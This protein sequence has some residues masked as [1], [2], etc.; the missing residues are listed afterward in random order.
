[1][2]GFTTHDT[3]THMY[4]SKA[5]CANLEKKLWTGCHALHQILDPV[6]TGRDVRSEASQDAKIPRSNSTVH[7]AGNK[8]HMTQVS[9]WDP[10]PFIC[11]QDLK[12]NWWE[13]TFP[14]F[15]WWSGFVAISMTIKFGQ[16][17]Q[18]SVNENS[19]NNN[20]SSVVAV[21]CMFAANVAPWQHSKSCV[22]CSQSSISTQLLSV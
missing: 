7:T 21:V 6:H 22:W 10:A 2:R 3:C 5:F 1:M 13:N 17:V 19:H 12:A 18:F 4:N 15:S 9:G 20:T 16:T 11:A 14:S 8:Q